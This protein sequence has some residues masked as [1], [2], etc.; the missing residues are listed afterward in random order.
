M[1]WPSRIER[2]ASAIGSLKS[3]PSTRTVYRPVIEPTSLVPERSRSFGSM[4]NTLGVK[5]RVAGGSPMARPTS[6]WAV[7]KRVTESII[8]MTSAPWSRKC[9]AIAVAV[10]AALM[11]TSAGWSEV[12][13]TTT[14]R[15]MAGPRSRSMNSRTSRPRSP[16]RQITLMSAD[17]ERAIIPSS[18]DLPTPE[19]AKMPSRWP[20][21]E[22]TSESS[23]RTPS[24]TRSMM[25]GRAGGDGAE[26]TIGRWARPSSGGPPS[27]G[28][29]KPSRT[30]PSSAVPGGTE[31]RRPGAGTTSPGPMPCISPIGMSSVRPERKPTTSA[32][33]V[34]QPPVTASRPVRTS[35][36]S[37]TSASRPV[38]ST[39]SPM[40]SLTRPCRRC[41]S[42][43]PTA[44]PSSSR[45]P[46]GDSGSA[47][48]A[49]AQL[50]L[51]HLAGAGQL[52]GQGGVDLA[53]DRADDRPATPHAALGLHV[54]VL[55]AAELG[56][57]ALG[58]AAHEVEVVGVDEDGH[59][60]A[61]DDAAQRAAHDVDDALGLGGDRAGQRL[62]GDAQTQLDG[63]GL[64]GGR[65]AVALGGQLGSGLLERGDG[66]RHLRL[67]LDAALEEALLVAGLARG[68]GL[69]GR[70]DLRRRRR[71][72]AD[73][74]PAGRLQGRELERPALHQMMSSSDSPS[75]SPRPMVMAPASSRRRM[76]ATMRDW[77]SSTTDRRCGLPVSSSSC[78]ISEPRWDMLR[79]MV[80]LT[81]SLTPRSAKARSFWSTSRSSSWMSR[82]LSTMMSSK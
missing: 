42:A 57:Q 77:A 6:R 62:L 79:K 56:H 81:S 30:R 7:A 75:P 38:A 76:A 19:P 80:S 10:S 9:S 25:R 21:P 12:A 26:P 52:G 55:D 47:S 23:A 43:R 53:L 51:E 13:T 11:R 1:M 36:T 58:G 29:P 68:L 32:G 37:P 78:S 59:A 22:G 69:G 34:V 27:I 61:L 60:V 71:G 40:R 66:G 3:S 48:S 70:V 28:L 63:G 46:A 24:V 2:T 33:R 20:R 18:E 44:R 35:Q 74:Q 14:E 31:T 82:S 64:D 41:R 50:L 8:N 67:G 65:H 73:D 49:I 4:A 16:T 17:V 5:P 72:Q 39:I 15:S 45:R 54:A